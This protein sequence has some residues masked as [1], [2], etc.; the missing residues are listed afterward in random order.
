MDEIF[1]LWDDQSVWLRFVTKHLDIKCHFFGPGQI[2]LD[3]HAGQITEPEVALAL[4]DFVRGLGDAVD[5][6]VHLTDENMTRFDV[7]VAHV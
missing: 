1:R 3:V 4:F 5:R 7:D 6:P 2:E